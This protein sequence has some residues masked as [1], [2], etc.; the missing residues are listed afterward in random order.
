M[1]WIK[2][3]LVFLLTNK[4]DSFLT[5]YKQVVCIVVCYMAVNVASEERE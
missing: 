5:N 1:G 2:I 4:D 3:E